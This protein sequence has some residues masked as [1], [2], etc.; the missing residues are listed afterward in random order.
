MGGIIRYK[1]YQ[2][3]LLRVCFSA[4]SEVEVLSNEELCL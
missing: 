3:A 2:L 1:T 4:H